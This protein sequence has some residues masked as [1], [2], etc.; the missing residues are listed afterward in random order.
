[1]LCGVEKVTGSTCK[2]RNENSTFCVNI[3]WSFKKWGKKFYGDLLPN[4]RIKMA[5]AKESFSSPTA[6]ALYCK[7]LVNPEKRSRCGWG[8]VYYKG[9][10]LELWKSVWMHN[11]TLN[12]AAVNHD[13]KS[14]RNLGADL[15]TNGE[16]NGRI[17]MPK[18]SSENTSYTG[19]LLDTDSVPLDLTPKPAHTG[20]ALSNG[21][22]SMQ[23]SSVDD[24]SYQEEALN[25]SLKG[26]SPESESRSRL[27]ME[28]NNSNN[29]NNSGEKVSIKH[30]SLKKRSQNID[31][32]TLVE[33]ET[34]DCLG[35]IQP[36]TVSIATNSLLLMDFHCHL[37]SS[38]VVGYLGG[39]WDP[40]TQHLSIIQAFSC[41]CRL[42][43]ATRAMVVEEEKN[44]ADF[45]HNAPDWL[46][47]R[48]LWQPSI[49]YLDKLKASLSTKLP[50]DQ[51]EKGTF[52]DFVHHLLIPK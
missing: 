15:G 34:F 19:N 52:L 39:K 31:P 18:S 46:K 41:Q 33:C 43:D 26:P 12:N 21:N 1:I 35:K 28:S 51:M 38:E 47:F 14:P 3:S 27:K 7:K 45:F 37:T 22:K 16:Q 50:E 9:K 40:K 32:N 29:N 30:S 11:H 2:Q 24:S 42:A 23:R 36:F 4:G 5:E 44:T 25:L 10:K 48:Q 8:M 13:S 17:L 20:T 6:W 49:T